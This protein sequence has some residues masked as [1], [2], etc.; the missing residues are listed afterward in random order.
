MVRTERVGSINSVVFY[1][2]PLEDSE[3]PYIGGLRIFGSIRGT[4]DSC[5][6]H[7][8]LY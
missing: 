5:N 4:P 6:P 8:S 7:A 3:A 1:L 2:G